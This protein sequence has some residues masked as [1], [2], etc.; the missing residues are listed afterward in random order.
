MDYDDHEEGSTATY[1]YTATTNATTTISTVAPIPLT[2][3][4]IQD[5]WAQAELKKENYIKKAFEREQQFFEQD[6]RKQDF[7]KSQ[8]N[9]TYKV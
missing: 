5:K 7:M 3:T 9:S 6:Q 1:G 2:Q 8:G 4:Q